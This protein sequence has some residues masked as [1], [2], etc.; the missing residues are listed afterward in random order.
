MGAALVVTIGLIAYHALF[1]AWVSDALRAELVIPDAP[2][3]SQLSSWRFEQW[4][5]ASRVRQSEA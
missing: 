3:A 2:V 4:V 1:K 5:A